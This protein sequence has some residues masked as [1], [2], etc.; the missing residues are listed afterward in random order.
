M[1]Y[2]A[3]IGRREDIASLEVVQEYFVRMYHFK[4]FSLDRKSILEEF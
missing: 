3:L 4:G 2:I 1:K